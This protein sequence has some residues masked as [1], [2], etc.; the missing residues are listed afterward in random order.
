MRKMHTA[1]RD[2]WDTQP[3]PEKRAK[4]NYERVFSLDE[5]QQIAQG[6]IPHAMEDKWFVFLEEDRLYF[7]RSWTG[8]CVYGLQLERSQADARVI[9]SWVNRDESQY[10][11]TDLDY[12]RQL[13][14]FLIDAFLLRQPAEFP[15]R[16][17]HAKDNPKGV[18][19]RHL[20]RRGYPEKI[21]G[22]G[23][24]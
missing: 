21:V 24:E 16:H 7:H 5:M 22:D 12:D 18:Y 8:I 15:I 2:D 6:L 9:D 11:E 3:T 1:K 23:E 10:S 20:I 4:L 17:S 19:Q 14:G 13:L